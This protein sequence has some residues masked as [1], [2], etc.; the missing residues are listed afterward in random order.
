[1]LQKIKDIM[2]YFGF[3]HYR[4]LCSFRMPGYKTRKVFMT[5]QNKKCNKFI[6]K[7]YKLGKRK[8]C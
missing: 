5:C 1:M 3:H 6:E 8:D 2:C 7:N 4:L